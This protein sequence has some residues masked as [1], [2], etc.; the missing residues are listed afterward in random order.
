M[1]LGFEPPAIKMFMAKIMRNIWPKFT[2]KANIDTNGLARDKEVVRAYNSDPL[3]HNDMTVALFFPL[4][5]NGL[6][7][8][9]HA[10]SLKTKLLLL[11]GSAD[12]LTSPEGS[13]LFSEKAPAS[14]L[15]YQSLEGYF[16]EIH[17]E[18]TE[19]R[20][21]VLSMISGWVLRQL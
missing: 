17:N 5:E 10:A 12:R 2:E 1:K 20:E 19:D 16:H 4:F 14:L 13:R 8:I 7:A 21:K 15:T 3:V 6:W 18:P 11:H 9:E